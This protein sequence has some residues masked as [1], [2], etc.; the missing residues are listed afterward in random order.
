MILGRTGDI[1]ASEPVDPA[2]TPPGSTPPATP[3]SNP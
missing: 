2:T 1:R 3:E